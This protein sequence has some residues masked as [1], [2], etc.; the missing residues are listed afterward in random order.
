MEEQNAEKIEITEPSQEDR[1]SVVS[2][3]W[4]HKGELRAVWKISI[5]LLF[6]F[7]STF[8]C[9]IAI[10]FIPPFRQKTMVYTI[11]VYCAI[12]IATYL[13]LKLIEGK[14]FSSIGLQFKNIWLRQ[15]TVGILFSFFAIVVIVLIELALGIVRIDFFHAR[16]DSVV[17][18]FGEG[19]IVFLAVGFGEE[20]L[21]RGYCFQVVLKGTNAAVA[22]V[23][24]SLAFS[25]AHFMNP[26]TTTISFI[27]IALAGVWLA[28][29]FVR[30]NHLWLAAGFHTAW[31]FTQGT[32]FGFPVSG[33][34]GKS[35]FSSIELGDDWITGGSFGPEGGI[36]ATVVLL[37]SISVLY[38]PNFIKVYESKKIETKSYTE[39][40][41]EGL[42]ENSHSR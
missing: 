28:L 14:S 13:V 3:F 41:S 22:I 25:A 15:F 35:I 10:Q 32:I 20:V 17:I 21:F 29:S 39:G 33:I 34:G 7:V 40:T 36:V 37:I 19:M 5:F 27:N 9:M 42:D 12:F 8:V 6:L 31:N 4:F 11:A 18:G 23:L 1:Q 24:S 16:V 30:T 26:N 38:Y 2:N